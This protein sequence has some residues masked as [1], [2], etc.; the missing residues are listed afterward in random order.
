MLR[1]AIMVFLAL[2]PETDNPGDDVKKYQQVFL[3]PLPGWHWLKQF[4][5]TY[6]PQYV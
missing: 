4:T 1:H 5:N 6:S 3:A 2:L